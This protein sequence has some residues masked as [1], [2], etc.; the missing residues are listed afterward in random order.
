MV[1][2]DIIGMEEK[3]TDEVGNEIEPIIEKD[4]FVKL[5]ITKEDIDQRINDLDR[6]VTNVGTTTS[7]S[8]TTT[9]T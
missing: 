1:N 6:R 3:E 7:T 4:E 5:G 8:T 2:N 9:T